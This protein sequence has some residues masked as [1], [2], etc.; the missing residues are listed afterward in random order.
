[1]SSEQFPNP[2]SLVQIEGAVWQLL[3]QAATAR[4]GGWRLPALATVSDGVVRQRTVVLRQVDI[5]PRRILVHTDARS[6]K[7]AAIHQ[8]PLVSWLLYDAELQ[9]QLHLSGRAEVHTDDQTAQEMW[10]QEPESS[11]RAY[12]GPLR[13]GTACDAVEPNLPQE[14]LHELPTRQQLQA[15]RTNFAVISCRVQ[16][17][18]WLQLGKHGHRR[19]IFE[20]QDG[21][22][23][24][25]SWVAP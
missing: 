11:L 18:E 22:L 19:A 9:V 6:Q 20:Y 23:V 8:Q 15:A 25:S 7:V 21:Q 24:D 17:A 10:D 16:S 14:F 13:P 4:S 1:M 3:Q 2:A 5:L 12:L